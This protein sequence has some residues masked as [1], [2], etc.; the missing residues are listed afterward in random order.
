M[1]TIQNGDSY[2]INCLTISY[3]Y[4]E[5]IVW[6][7]NIS[8]LHSVGTVFELQPRHQHS[9]LNFAEFILIPPDNV[10]MVP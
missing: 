10:R 1:D 7:S 4:T 2:L 5:G 8:D 6:N 3:E 9:G